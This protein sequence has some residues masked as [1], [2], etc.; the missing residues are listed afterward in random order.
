MVIHVAKADISEMAVDAVVVPSNSQGLMASGVALAVKK[1]GGDVIEEEARALAPIAIGAAIVTGPGQLFCKHVI[2]VPVTEEPDVRV[3]IENA[4][5]A[6]RAA[7]IAAS[8]HSLDVIALPGIGTGAGGLM[9]DEAA[10]AIIDELR[11]HRGPKPT[12]VYLV[13]LH[14]AMLRAFEEAFI[15]LQQPHGA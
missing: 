6:T 2:H 10:R 5:R 15:G 9:R 12:T 11:T 13:D 14:D 7:L 4:R 3:E 1:R 8:A